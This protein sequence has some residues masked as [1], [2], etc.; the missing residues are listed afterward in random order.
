MGRAY[1]LA[2]AIVA[3]TGDEHYLVGST[4]EPCDFRAHGFESPVEIDAKSRPFV[5]LPRAGEARLAGTFL[6]LDAEG[7]DLP[8][9]LADRFLIERNGSVSERLWRLVVCLGDADADPPREAAVDARWL[10]AMPSSIWK[11][12]R[13]SVLRCV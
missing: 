8:R 7:E 9:T 6:E 3:E 10:G 1:R 13:D 2:G 4:K 11:L 12:V 5:R